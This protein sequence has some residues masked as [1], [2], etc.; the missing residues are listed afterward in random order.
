[1]DVPHLQAVHTITKADNEQFEFQA[2]HFDL[3]SG[4]GF[5]TPENR[6]PMNGTYNGVQNT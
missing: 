2:R 1:M 3:Q 5:S 4:Q 6:F